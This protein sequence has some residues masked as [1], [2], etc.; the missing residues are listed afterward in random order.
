MVAEG[1]LAT[2]VVSA[3]GVLL[4]DDGSAGRGYGQAGQLAA[5]TQAGQEHRQERGLAGLPLAGQQ[6]DVAGGQVA[7]Y[8]PRYRGGGLA[9][10]GE[11]KLGREDDGTGRSGGRSV[12][13]IGSGTPGASQGTGTMGFVSFHFSVSFHFISPDSFHGARG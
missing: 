7:V 11:R 12:R 4:G 13:D 10:V 5:G 3:G 6:R 8:Q 1:E 9:Q 2:A